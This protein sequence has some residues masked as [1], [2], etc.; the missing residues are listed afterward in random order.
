VKAPLVNLSIEFRFDRVQLAFVAESFPLRIDDHLKT[1]GIK[2]SRMCYL[3]NN[4][5]SH[6]LLEWVIRLSC[7]KLLDR[8][9][10]LHVRGVTAIT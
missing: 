6:Y 7:V 2:Q 1:E 3:T 9:S 4:L 8:R 5:H 10:F